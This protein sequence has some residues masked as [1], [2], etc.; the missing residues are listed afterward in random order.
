MTKLCT[1]VCTTIWKSRHL[2]HTERAVVV[3]YYSAFIASLKTYRLTRWKI[4][5]QSASP[6]Q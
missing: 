6:P 2:E 5:S 4:S 1:A 3:R